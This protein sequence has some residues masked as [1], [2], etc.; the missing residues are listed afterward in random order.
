MNPYNLPLAERFVATQVAAAAR[1]LE[2]QRAE[3]SAA[4]LL[5]ISREQ[6]AA[7]LMQMLPA[8]AARLLA[9]V[10]LDIAG[11]LLRAG[12]SNQVAAILRLAPRERRGRLLGHLPEQTALRCRIKIAHAADT[13]GAWME[14]DN[15]LL[16]A[17]V[18]VG[19]ALKR[20]AA[21]DNIGDGSRIPLVDEGRKLVGVVDIG[22]LLRARRGQPIEQLMRP[23]DGLT[24]QT[25]T[26]LRS[27]FAHEGWNRTDSL[28][29]LNQQGQPVG[30]L[31]HAT[32]R[33]ALRGAGDEAAL[34]GDTSPLGVFVAAYQH[35]LGAIA[36]LF[37]EP[38]AATPESAADRGPRP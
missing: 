29:V 19:D 23:P 32:L 37:V 5:A 13:V 3:R 26:S 17:S 36:G 2:L 25:R 1:E 11:E 35:A 38:A 9:Q 10:P 6:A 8:Y 22:E 33:R 27:A 28:A 21:A 15:L 18:S 16:P 12:N 24:V 14:A 31:R 20:I 7:V 34:A 30:I 4:F